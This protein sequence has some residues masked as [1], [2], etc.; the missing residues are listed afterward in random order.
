MTFTHAAV[1]SENLVSK[2]PW[3]LF[4]GIGTGY[5]IVSGSSY[6]ENPKGE[7]FL[8]NTALSYQ[9]EK[10]VLDGGVGWIYSHL[11]GKLSSGQA[12]QIYT[13]SGL[14]ELSPRYKFSERWQIGPVAN[15]TFGTDTSLGSSLGPT[16]TSFFAGVKGV[17]ETQLTQLPLRLWAQL[18]TDLTLANQQA[19]LAWAGIQIGIPLTRKEAPP[20]FAAPP[21]V[22]QTVHIFLDPQ[23]VFFNT[24]SAALKRSVAASLHD[25]G[26]YIQENESSSEIKIV[27]HADQRGR[28]KYNLAL[29]QRRAAAVRRALIQ[30]GIESEK[31]SLQGESFLQPFDPQQNKT[32]WA[33]NRRVELTFSQV[34]DPEILRAKLKP[35]TATGPLD[36]H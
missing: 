23:R 34:K 15:M 26:M 3:T 19:T 17:Y 22:P 9:T 4:G 33:K 2:T 27:G 35:L 21:P 14:V 11:T 32:A 6:S 13:R 29:S 25:V 8:L 1:A 7:Q 16:S 10:W 36:V 24:N 12:L 18:T 28:F 30:G 20:V 5:G 31:F